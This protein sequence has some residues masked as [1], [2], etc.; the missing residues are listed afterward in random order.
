MTVH[1]HWLLPTGGDGRTLV[2][3]RA[4]APNELGAARKVSG[5]R[6]PDIEYLAQLAARGLL[7]SAASGGGSPI[8]VASGR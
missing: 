1:L 3:R 8:L 6:A 2:D 5:V 7:E 4:Y